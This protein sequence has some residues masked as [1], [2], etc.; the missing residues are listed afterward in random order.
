MIRVG[1]DAILAGTAPALLE[2]PQAVEAHAV[3]ASYR[4]TVESLERAEGLRWDG[5]RHVAL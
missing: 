1:D 5:E 3:S 4:H 2:G